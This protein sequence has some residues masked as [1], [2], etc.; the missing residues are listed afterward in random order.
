MIK[1]KNIIAKLLLFVSLFSFMGCSKSGNIVNP[2]E[3]FSVQF[4]LVEPDAA[5]TLTIRD[6]RTNEPIGL[7][8]PTSGNTGSGNYPLHVIV[9]GDTE[10]TEYKKEAITA[11]AI[12]INEGNITIEIND[13]TLSET[14]PKALTFYIDPA[15]NY[16]ST[17]ID[18]SITEAEHHNYEIKMLKV[19]DISAV[20]GVDVTERTVTLSGTGE[21]PALTTIPAGAQNVSIPAGTQILSNG[22]P[23]SGP[24]TIRVIGFSATDDN[25]RELFP[26]GFTIN[27]FKEGDTY[28]DSPGLFITGGFVAVD[29]LQSG[30]KVPNITLANNTATLSTTIP[31]EVLTSIAGNENI[32]PNETFLWSYKEGVW[33]KEAAV[34]VPSNG[35]VSASVDH[36][37]Y[38]NWDWHY[39]PRYHPKLHIEGRNGSP[40]RVLS[41][42]NNRRH[43]SRRTLY[44]DVTQLYNVPLNLPIKIEAYIGRTKVGELDKPN[45]ASRSDNPLVLNVDTEGVTNAFKTLSINLEITDTGNKPSVRPYAYYI[46][47][48]SDWSD[49]GWG[50]LRN[51]S[52]TIRNLHVGESY[53]IFA[54]IPYARN[55]FWGR[56]TIESD[57]PNVLNLS[58]TGEQIGYR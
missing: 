29:F 9:K 26:G 33:T 23:I 14:D 45:G 1:Y 55:Y 54:Y 48:L 22:T 21:I 37:S 46:Y 57:T 42:I 53:Y 19:T 24:T 8:L 36:F 50:R 39:S 41:Y 40:I 2:F 17:G 7:T 31:N 56:S 3:D 38:W 28:Q 51:G 34:N 16:L 43:W 52:T 25:A 32:D 12:E 58:V 5:V 10:N 13:N 6:A 30:S 49:Y 44:K 18:L 15:G 47:V 20:S 4:A 27:G 35:A 11:S